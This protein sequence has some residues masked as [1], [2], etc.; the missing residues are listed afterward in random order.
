MI[1]QRVPFVITSGVTGLTT[2]VS[3]RGVVE[4]SARLAV[5]NGNGKVKRLDKVI[6][7]ALQSEPTKEN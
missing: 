6:V 1:T 7:A 3:R 5:T 4:G 2:R